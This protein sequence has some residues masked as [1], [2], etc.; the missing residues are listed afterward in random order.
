MWAHCPAR[1]L[2]KIKLQLGY[3]LNISLKQLKPWAQQAHTQSS[4]PHKLGTFAHCFLGMIQDTTLAGSTISRVSTSVS[5]V[6]ESSIRLDKWFANQ[7]K[8]VPFEDTFT[9]DVAVLRHITDFQTGKRS[10]VCYG[11]ET[12][13]RQ[14]KGFFGERTKHVLAE[15]VVPQQCMTFVQSYEVTK[16]ADGS[17]WRQSSM[18]IRVL[19]PSD[20]YK[21][22]LGLIFYSERCEHLLCLSGFTGNSVM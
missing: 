20:D 15:V 19:D 14:D 5:G 11:R 22:R 4:M 2:D 13:E 7:A 16:E 9:Q 3:L 6:Q 17:Q 1:R 12:L 18:R 8:D 21:L 10:T